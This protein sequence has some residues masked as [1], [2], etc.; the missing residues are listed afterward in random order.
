LIIAPHSAAG[1]YVIKDPATSAYYH[2]GPEE[3]LLLR[4]LDGRQNF[5]SIARR[6]E[7]TFGQALTRQDLDDFIELANSMNLLARDPLIERMADGGAAASTAPVG[8]ATPR[9]APAAGKTDQSILFW[10]IRLFDP[11]RLF[12]WLAPKLRFL[13]TPAFVIVSA[14][15]MLAAFAI[16]WS[17]RAELVSRFADVLSWQTFFIA[18]LAIVV[19]TT[20][21]EFAHGLT[22]KHFGGEVRDLGFLLL[23]FMPAFY[24]NVSD[25][26]LFREKSKRLWV[27]LAGGY[28]DLCLWAMAVFVW[29]L[30]MQDSLINY[31]AWVIMTICGVRSLFNFLPLI[32]LDGYYLLS[33]L[34]S[35]PNLRQRGWDTF[36]GHVRWIVWGAA[37]PPAE[38]KRAYLLLFGAGVWLY[39]MFFL[40]VLAVWFIWWLGNRWGP[41]ATLGAAG[42][43]A[44]VLYKQFDGLNRGEV[45]LMWRDRKLRV[46]ALVLFLAG[47]TAALVL[48]PLEEKATGEFQLRAVNRLELRAP[49]AGYLEEVMGDE[50]TRMAAGALAARMYI[51]DLELRIV[52]KRAEATEQEAKL[53]LLRFGSEPGQAESA[54]ALQATVGR[55]MEELRYLEAL[56][57]KLLVHSSISG[58][59]STP[60]LREKVGQFF[61]DGELICVI[62]E[63]ADLEVR[64]EV[65]EQE[66]ERV[67]PGQAVQLKARALPFEQ[68]EATVDR[69]APVAEAPDPKEGKLQSMVPVYC[70]L[71]AAAP[72]ALRPGMTGF[73]RVS[74]GERAA[75]RVLADKALRYVRTEFWW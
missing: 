68:F 71:N 20:C 75:G 32:K 36:W 42:L 1:E 70:R 64:V 48:V 17:N 45:M 25:A 30:T 74:C 29:R 13:W 58:V 66:V 38:P 53:R 10:R 55:T 12:G 47:V 51:P 5:E 3:S 69:I 35:T 18:W 63:P 46:L 22:C 57:K 52:Q 50:G 28:C 14:A 40:S 43:A 21:H 39:S 34:T 72:A 7:Q 23:F 65:P 9:A 11:D 2:L 15:A 49:M 62:E 31:L 73:A 33:D 19:A 44:S 56:K 54:S 24:A 26:W 61:N 41:I 60:R 27:T 4:A 37:R 6:F 67:R 16:S 8:F 59:I